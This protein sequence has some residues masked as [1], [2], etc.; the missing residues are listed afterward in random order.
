MMPVPFERLGLWFNLFSVLFYPRKAK[1]HVFNFI[2]RV[3]PCGLVIDLGGGTG[4]LLNLAHTIRN[5]LTYICV[6]PAIGMLKY[7]RPYAYRVAAR[8]ENLPFSDNA[9]AAVM[10]G[11]AI[12]HFTNPERG[13]KEV[14]RVLRLGGKLF[15]FDI[16]PKRYVGRAAVALEKLLHEPVNFYTPGQL[17][18]LLAKKGFKIVAQGCGGR[19]TLEAEKHSP[20]T[21][22]YL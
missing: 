2:R 5:D 4:T 12:H 10:I 14:H 1:Q 20:N 11:D 16:N 6:D 21:T 22:E 18:D 3:E 19:Y 7:V 9:V 15:I 13:F 8:S 17:C